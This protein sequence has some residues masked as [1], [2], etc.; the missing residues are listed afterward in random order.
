MNKG[1]T[2]SVILNFNKNYANSKASQFTQLVNQ[3]LEINPNAMVALYTG[4]LVRKPIVLP[5][6]T[7]LTINLTSQQPTKA[8]TGSIPLSDNKTLTVLLVSKLQ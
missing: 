1:D 2:Q 5:S 8:M 6:D 4:N 7:K 3:Q